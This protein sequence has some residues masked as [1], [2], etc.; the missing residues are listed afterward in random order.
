MA[1]SPSQHQSTVKSVTWKLQ[2]WVVHFTLDLARALR[3]TALPQPLVKSLCCYNVVPG[4]RRGFPLHHDGGS[5]G[6]NETEESQA[7]AQ[8]LDPGVCHFYSQKQSE[9]SWDWEC[10]SDGVGCGKCAVGGFSSVITCSSSGTTWSKGITHKAPFRRRTSRRTSS[11][12]HAK[13]KHKT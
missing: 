13:F 11:G 9:Q 5:D 2:E 4:I 12:D 1:G 8:Q 3:R 7:E 6:T 10:S